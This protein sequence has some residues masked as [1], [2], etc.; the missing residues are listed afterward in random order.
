MVDVGYTTVQ[1]TNQLV[2]GKITG[3]V[4]DVVDAGRMGKIKVGQDNTLVM[5]EL[6]TYDKT[7]IQAAADLI[8]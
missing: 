7:N 6:Q 8:T 4:G 2:H 1:A 5:G 3:A